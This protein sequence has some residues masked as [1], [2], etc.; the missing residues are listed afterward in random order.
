MLSCMT[1]E[2]RFLLG[3]GPF[4][5][6]HHPMAGAGQHIGRRS[7]PGAAAHDDKVHGARLVHWQARVRGIDE[8]PRHATHATHAGESGVTAT[9][10]RRGSGPADVAAV[11][12]PYAPMRPSARTSPSSMEQNDSLRNKAAVRTR[13]VGGH[14][15]PLEQ[16]LL[17]I[18]GERAEAR[19]TAA[20]SQRAERREPHQPQREPRHERR[21]PG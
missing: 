2:S 19:E 12:S 11:P 7:T 9:G 21:F 10:R 13:Y 3:H 14:E 15:Q 5:E 17:I 4:F 8:G 1:G 6:D 16:R 20:P 18:A